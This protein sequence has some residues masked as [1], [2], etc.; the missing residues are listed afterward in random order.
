MIELGAFTGASALWIADSLNG[1]DIE[2]N[3][4]S[5]DIDLSLLHPKIDSLRPP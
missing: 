4:F 2:C 1:A 3:V 5:A